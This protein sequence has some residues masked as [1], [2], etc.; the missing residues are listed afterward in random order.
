MNQAK[1]VAT[2]L[3]LVKGLGDHFQRVFLETLF[4]GFSDKKRL[5][6]LEWTCHTLYPETRW[7]KL[8]RW[9]EGMFRGD[10]NRSPGKVASM[11]VNYFRMKSRMY[12][13]LVKM[14]QRIKNRVLMRQRRHPEE[15]V[16]QEDEWQG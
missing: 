2:G 12:P 4:N 1:Y 14:A 5:Q 13:F 6:W 10:M 7:M 15:N 8:D 11:S 3:R 9:M 16:E